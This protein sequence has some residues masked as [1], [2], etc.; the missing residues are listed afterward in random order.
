MLP[1]L[2]R[3]R[4]EGFEVSVAAVREVDLDERD[5]DE[6]EGEDE[7]PFFGGPAETALL[8]CIEGEG[9][10]PLELLLAAVACAGSGGIRGIPVQMMRDDSVSELDL[11]E[12]NIGVEGGMLLAY[13]VPV[14]GALTVTNLLGNQLDAESA[15]MLAEVAKK[16]GI[17]LCGIQRDQTIADFHYKRLKPPDAIL[18]ASDLSQAVVTGALTK[19]SL[20]WNNLE[21]EGTKT[22]CEALKQN[23]TL[24]ELDLDRSTIGGEAGAKHVADMLGVNGGLTRL[25]VRQNK[26]A[27][28]GAAQLAAAVLGNLKIEMFNEIPIKEMRADSFT[29][30]DLKEK[31][32]GV[33]GSMVVAGL[34]PAM[35]GLTS[36]DLSNNAF[37]G[38]TYGGGTYTA[39]GI[40]AIADA[41]RVNGVLTKL[42]L[43]RNNL[44]EEG[45]KAICEA[46]EQNTTLKELDISGDSRGSNIDGSAGVNHVAKMLGVN[47]ALTALNLSFNDLEDEGVS[48]VCEAIKSN[49]DTKLTLLNFKTNGIG[50]E[51]SKSVADM[52]A[53]TGGLTSLDLSNNALCGVTNYGDTY[54]AE[55]ITAIADALRV[56][57][58]L[59]R[60]DV[61][62]NN[63]AGD[64]AAHLAAAVLSNL[65]IEMFNEIP[66]K[67]MRAN[68]FTE[69][70]LNGK[71]VGVVGGMVVAGLIPVMGALTKI[72]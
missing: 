47:S 65:K 8:S 34:M 29:E 9:E 3:L 62:N 24:K 19:L 17:S 30:L 6:V 16:K 27:G 33:E 21:E 28:D 15:K 43:A 54:I 36:L 18:L 31:H 39:E 67:E 49:K 50:P 56:N 71:R 23:K 52:V 22:I 42:S 51:G 57:G 46:L 14:M 20:R 5:A 68:S 7:M 26:I 60:V 69:L 13:L 55:G 25:D 38:V 66:I 48:A 1:S 58:A 35:G 53:V 41:L 4:W 70:D 45:T 11:Q 72:K 2:A 59:T 40:I 10:P 37:C 32:F 12:R 63:I 44:K 64:G 61:R